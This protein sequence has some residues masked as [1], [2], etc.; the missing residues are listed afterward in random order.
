M[1]SIRP[2]AGPDEAASV[3]VNTPEAGILCKLSAGVPVFSRWRRLGFFAAL[4]LAA[5][6]GRAQDWAVGATYGTLADLERSFRLDNFHP[7]DV[8]AWVD[9]RIEPH[10]LLRA[11]YVDI[12]AKGDNAGHLASVI[13]GQ[14]P[15]PLPDLK[16]G[17][18][19][20]TLGV[21][22]QFVEGFYTSGIFAGVGAYRIRPDL[23]TPEFAPFVDARET[24]LGL[25]VGVEGDFKIVKR[26]SLVGRITLHYIR[27]DTRRSLL[28]AAAGAV[29]HL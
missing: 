14:P 23:T 9:F 21:S 5:A 2:R 1:R 24:A 17:I 25:H 6:S 4:F 28:S 29:F 8:S 19:A 16:V 13:N 7:R 27:S 10:T 20:V 26:L 18:S 12:R 11:S 3:C 22:Y 15:A